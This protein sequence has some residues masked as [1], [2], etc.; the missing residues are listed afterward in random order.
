M[1]VTMSGRNDFL[2]RG[3][4]DLCVVLYDDVN[5]TPVFDLPLKCQ[6]FEVMRLTIVE[7]AMYIAITIR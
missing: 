7:G 5:F 1:A 4:G 2:Y 3:G 6:P